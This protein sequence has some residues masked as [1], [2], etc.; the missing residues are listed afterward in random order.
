MKQEFTITV[1]T[2]NHIGILGRLSLIF[3]RRNMGIKT[4]N[5]ADSSVVGI[6]KI[7]ITLDALTT[8]VERL[9]KQI[10]KQIDVLMVFYHAYDSLLIESVLHKTTDVYPHDLTS[11]VSLINNQL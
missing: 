6:K 3:S 5:Y 11:N 2:E 10:E 4:L 7:N 1:F 8:Q 9:V